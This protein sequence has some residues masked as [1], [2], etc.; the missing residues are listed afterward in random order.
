MQI[1]LTTHVIA[2]LLMSFWVQLSHAN[3]TVT[4]DRSIVTMNDIV[5]L[6][7]RTE[8]PDGGAG[9]NIKI[10]EKDF[11]IL[12]R[13]S[14]VA[15]S[16]RNGKAHQSLSWVYQV[17]PKRVGKIT[18]PSLSYK[19]QRSEPVILEVLSTSS[20][21]K[22][23]QT[24][25]EA[26]PVELNV[27][28]D[29][30]TAYIEEQLVLTMEIVFKTSVN[31]AGLSE[32]EIP[33][34]IIEQL[35]EQK[36]F[37]RRVGD[38][39]EQVIEQKFALY[40]LATGQ[41][42]IPPM[43]LEAVIP[44]PNRRQARRRSPLDDFMNPFGQRGGQK[45][46][47]RQSE[48]LSLFVKA[49]PDNYPKDARWIPASDVS[50]TQ[51][52]RPKPPS[53]QVGDPVTRLLT[54]EVVGQHQKILPKLPPRDTPDLKIYSDKSEHTQRS[55]PTGLIAQRSDSQAIIP[56]RSGRITLPEEKMYWWNTQKD[57][58]ESIVLPA[59]GFDAAAA[60]GSAAATQPAIA[61]TQPQ[62]QPSLA[63]AAP[64]Q[65]P[66][67]QTIPTTDESVIDTIRTNNSMLAMQIVVV[68]CLALS[69]CL[70]LWFWMHNRNRKIKQL[71]T[72]QPHQE[73]ALTLKAAHK[74]IIE[75]CNQQHAK[76]TKQAL[77]SWAQLRFPDI[78]IVSLLQLKPLC[79]KSAFS[80]ELDHLQA[81]LYTSNP[82]DWDSRAFKDAFIK[83]E[84]TLTQK[85]ESKASNG[86]L[87]P[88]YR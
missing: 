22:T 13:S 69:T 74:K 18:I 33:D 28:L 66:T 83:W 67:N 53:F 77:V 51:Q 30:T 55:T 34:M 12:N 38:R 16:I 46:I 25:S 64:Q 62:P 39:T 17:L 78:K 73:K 70:N 50:W 65:P 72:K 47:R 49:I 37:N 10:I 68:I 43:I 36:V 84:A 88:L 87:A 61:Q 3:L 60:A 6:T 59:Y 71:K 75:A 42:S 1:K 76:A 48:R 9:P 32:L 79:Q 29:K 8:S 41:L 11:E 19:Q 63:E 82:S 54:L 80:K 40:P 57:R 24:G 31:D 5:V 86:K 15:T 27:S 81:K 23:Y 35:G 56:M 45:K 52:W 14:N 4:L 7:I 2:L 85:M 26:D 58:L 21:N 44:D 20:A